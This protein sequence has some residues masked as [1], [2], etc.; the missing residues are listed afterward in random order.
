MVSERKIEANVYK[1][2]DLTSIW[3]LILDP[4]LMNEIEIDDSFVTFV[5]KELHDIS[6]LP[7]FIQFFQ[8]FYQYINYNIVFLM[9]QINA[10]GNHKIDN[11]YIEDY[12]FT[13][14]CNILSF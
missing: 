14:L 13:C 9:Y 4:S 5:S 11:L 8:I 3:I 6:F 7:N 12:L 1:T 10:K 2:I